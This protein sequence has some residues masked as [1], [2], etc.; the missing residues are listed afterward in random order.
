M[1]A[2]LLA[3]LEASAD[4]GAY[5]DLDRTHYLPGQTAV[6]E[7]YVYVPEKQADVFERGPFYLYVVPGGA[8]VREG[9]P[10][11][12]GAIRL[13]TVSFEKH[14]RE[15]YEGHV[16]FTVPDLPG[17]YYTLA[18][19]NDPCTISGFREPLTAT[20]SIVETVREG[21]LLNVYQEL[22]GSVWGLRHRVKKADRQKA[23]LEATL[24]ESRDEVSTLS[25]EVARLEAELEDASA[26]ATAAMPSATRAPADADRPLVDAWAA[27]AIVGALIAALVAIALALVFSR[28]SARRFAVPDT[29]EELD[30]SVADLVRG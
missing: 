20:I 28:R 9:E 8:G 15:S 17:E 24:A 16:T 29:I 6:G 23:E 12:D 7:A 14:A 10:I 22:W 30:G 1:G 4:G 2:L 27:V 26:P 3:P 21:E 13:G 25:A 11:P 5:I 19:C 18:V